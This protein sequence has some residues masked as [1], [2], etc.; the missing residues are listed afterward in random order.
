MVRERET[1]EE[2]AGNSILLQVENTKKWRRDARIGGLVNTGV[3]IGVEIVILKGLNVETSIPALKETIYGVLSFIPTY[4]V[5]D[6]ITDMVKGGHHYLSLT[7][8]KKLSRNP[9]T[10]LRL[11]ESIDRMTGKVNT[12]VA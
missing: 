5:A 12:T 1:G 4:L 10:K 6:G 8:W 11:Q 3:G 9:Q 2:S 7:I